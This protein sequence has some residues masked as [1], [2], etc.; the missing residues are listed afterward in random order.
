[1]PLYEYQCKT[2]LAVTEQ[3]Q[4]MANMHVP[5]GE[6]CAECGALTVEKVMLTAPSIGDPVRLG[7]RR[8]SGALKE[9]L[10]KVHESTPGSRLNS[11]S[12][13]I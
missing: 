11:T 13:H 2:C 9:V 7:I 4:T 12:S 10:Q 1:M 3:S 5:E 6:P 8:P